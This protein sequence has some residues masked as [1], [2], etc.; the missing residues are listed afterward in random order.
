MMEEMRD[1]KRIFRGFREI[2]V[3]VDIR[4]LIYKKEQRRT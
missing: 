2:V 3:R 1:Y 4:K